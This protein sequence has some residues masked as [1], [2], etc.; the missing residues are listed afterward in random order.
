M[1]LES[2]NGSFFEVLIVYCIWLSINC[3]FHIYLKFIENLLF[4][5]QIGFKLIINLNMDEFL[6][7]MEINYTS[8]I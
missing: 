5:L 1:V 8:Q 4:I 2:N 7:E 6:I 3:Y